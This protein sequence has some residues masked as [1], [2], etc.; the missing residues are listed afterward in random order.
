MDGCFQ[1][2]ADDLL[3]ET[4]A[5]RTTIRLLDEAGRRRLV[6]ESLAPGTVSMSTG[7]RMPAE[8]DAYRFTISVHQRGATRRWGQPAIDALSR[9]RRSLE[10]H[11]A[12][13]S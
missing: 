1:R 10:D 2:L 9:A 5:S 7:P 12:A 13:A 11:L 8:H 6:A 4:A 3:A